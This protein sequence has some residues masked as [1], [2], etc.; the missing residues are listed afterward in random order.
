MPLLYR[1]QT[2]HDSHL[3]N[4]TDHGRTKEKEVG[5]VTGSE[6]RPAD[7]ATTQR[8]GEKITAMITDGS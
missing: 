4:S 3:L 7:N 8:G 6:H 2:S 5:N 1:I